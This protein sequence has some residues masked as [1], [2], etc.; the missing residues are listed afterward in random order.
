MYIQWR[1][2]SDLL[3]PE[4]YT[5]VDAFSTP[6]GSESYSIVDDPFMKYAEDPPALIA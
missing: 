6:D 3:T 1:G 2:E 4:G 5:N